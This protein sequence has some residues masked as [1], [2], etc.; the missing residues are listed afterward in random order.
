MKTTFN[1]EIKKKPNKAGQFPVFLRITKDRQHK[2]TKTSITLNSKSDWNPKGAKNQSWVRESEPKFQQWNDI[3]NDEL[4]E[5]I[6]TWREKKDATPEQVVSALK[7]GEDSTDS[8]FLKFAK[9]KV[10]EDSANQSIGTYRH[11]LS[12]IQQFEGFLASK[13][14]EDIAFEEINLALVKQYE[15]YLGKVR[16]QKTKTSKRTINK[17]TAN[18]YMRR[19]RTLV[20]WAESLGYITINPFGEGKGQYQIKGKAE[21]SKE[22]LNEG[23]LDAIIGLELPEGG[24]LWHTRNAFL[25]SLFCAGMR[26]GDVLQLRWKDID[27][28]KLVY[29]ADKTGK[30]K[31]FELVPDAVHILSMYEN[32]EAG[33]TDYIF[34]FLDSNAEWAKESLKGKDTMPEELQKAL[35][36]QLASK[37]VIL[38]KNLKK[39]MEQA[40]I[41]KHISFHC[42]RHSFANLAVES[43]LETKKVQGLLNHSS[44][45]TTENY[46]KS[47]SDKEESEA[48]AKVFG[49]KEQESPKDAL[50]KALKGLDEATLAEVLAGLK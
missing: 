42:A 25:F 37:N 4:Q 6:K 46:L 15:A 1:F 10:E 39:I 33:L 16:S 35:F 44:V 3:L 24:A 29:E 32:P 48:L 7:A 34:P 21:S 31:K 47:F 14:R 20:N 30:V 36:N 38:N 12:A 45:Q 41:Q 17:A 2:R 40:G 27:A 28:G 49:K 26:C 43:G 11:N 18:S 13:G 19:F 23:E 8:S 22:V 5:A 50:I 9:K